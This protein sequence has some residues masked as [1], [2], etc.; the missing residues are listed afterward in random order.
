MNGRTSHGF[1][2]LIEGH[3]FANRNEKIVEGR[4]GP[5]AIR[6]NHAA[7]ARQ[8]LSDEPNVNNAVVSQG[9]NGTHAQ[10]CSRTAVKYRAA[11]VT[12]VAGGGI[13]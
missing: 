7:D 1:E 13:R 8:N 12:N 6:R 4:R 9:K 11:G 10:M 3:V 5:A 2:G